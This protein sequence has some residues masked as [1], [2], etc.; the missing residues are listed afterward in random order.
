[1]TAATSFSN[2]GT[3]R[4]T[5]T[6]FTTSGNATLSLTAGTLT[7]TATGVIETLV[8]SGGGRNILANIVN[9]GSIDIQSPA[10]MN[11]SGAEYT[12]NNS[13]VVGA[14]HTLAV[15]GAFIQAGG[16]LT[17]DG[18]FDQTAGA[19]HL[20]GGVIAG[21][22]TLS[23]L[24]LNV[25]PG[26]TAIG[27][28][29]MIRA[30]TLS[31][32]VMAGQTI[33]I[34]GVRGSLSGPAVNA[35]LT[36]AGDFTNAGIIRLTSSGATGSGSS[37]L[38]IASGTLTNTAGGQI[39]T[40][41]GTGGGRSISGAIIND[42]SISLGVGTT[43][44]SGTMRNVAPG[45]IIGGST[46]TLGAAAAFVGSGSITANIVNAGQFHVGASPGL[47]SITGTY[48]QSAS[49][50]FHLEI[51]GSIAGSDFDRL[52]VS[53]A[54]SL[55]GTLNVS[56]VSGACTE[57]GSSYE[58]MTFA[59]RAGD[60]TVKNG[61]NP[62]AGQTY[63]TVPT[64]TNYRLNVI[65]AACPVPDNTAPV[66]SAQVVG[67][68]GNNDWYV[69][70]VTVTWQVIDL[71]SSILSS[72][73]CGESHVL[74]DNV[75]I[76][77][78]CSATSSGG[79]NSASV[80]IKR[81]ATVPLVLVDRAPLANAFGWNR[82]DVLATLSATDA[83]SGV[84]GDATGSLSFTSE[85]ENQSGSITFT[86]LA[87]N[88]ASGIVS[89]VSIDKT[90][91]TVE[92]SRS[93]EP[94]T[95]GWYNT[96]V[97]VTFSATDALSGIDGSMAEVVTFAA[98]GEN[99]SGSHTFMDRAGNSAV[100]IVNGVS[101][102]K[103]RPVIQVSRSLEPN[104]FGWNNTDVIATFSATDILSGIDGSATESIVF[105]AEGADQ[106]G[107][108]TFAD[109]A[110]NVASGT[111]DG[112]SIDRTEP[113]VLVNRSPAP[114]ASGW[115]N[116]DVTAT[117]EATDALSGIDGEATAIVIFSTDGADQGAT[118][119]FA[120]RAGNVGTGTVSGINIDR[121]GPAVGVACSAN[122][123]QLWSPNGRMVPVT[124]S[125]NGADGLS[126]VSSFLLRSV[127]S[128]ES[129]AATD[130]QSFLVGTADTQGSLRAARDGSGQ[131]RVYSLVYDVWDRSGNPGECVVRVTVPHDQRR[132][133]A[134]RGA[135]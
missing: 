124:V 52:V 21:I 57:T 31:G 68:L 73:G 98:E 10:S 105:S 115:N 55:A 125:F 110:G 22:P 61:L 39:E 59:S 44:S 86:D 1:L 9:N 27:T 77:F 126:T 49:G 102:D 100:G 14:T 11:R 84:D 91:P 97:L 32:N 83:T 36:A 65:G 67:T 103:T 120:D 132:I 6:G 24:S 101:I 51:G 45:T 7:N 94:N 95:F 123:S 122:P 128:N 74:N 26:S 47:L 82:T 5:S 114:D 135:K 129:Q 121:G 89:G 78:T 37:T 71:E 29:R 104:A 25:G 64:A 35:S 96:D 79:A 130:I 90:E 38:T 112:I 13:F 113:M 134:D 40:L 107:S 69:S 50:T 76:T 75:G 116:T 72:T 33:I 2:S 63:V 92:V 42:G 19:F 99:Q 43:Y 8:G 41:P 93:A 106:S 56:K 23:A 46:L 54:T 131:G 70:D 108:H 81:D 3:I 87:G 88:V 53:G 17:V 18:V 109:R 66:I 4:L 133:A 85:G 48:S 127:T 62:G 12:N 20:N 117:F 15:V 80:T 34:E 118:R 119:S 16:T 58:F 111:A 30:S 60:F 28:V